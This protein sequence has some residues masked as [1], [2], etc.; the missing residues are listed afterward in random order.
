MRKEFEAHGE[1]YVDFLGRFCIANNSSI[2]AGATKFQHY[3]RTSSKI[4]T[5]CISMDKHIVLC[6]LA[7]LLQSL[8]VRTGDLLLHLGTIVSD[9]SV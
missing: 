6:R 1:P 9:T 2:G 4:N 7:G 8:V 3:C 5:K